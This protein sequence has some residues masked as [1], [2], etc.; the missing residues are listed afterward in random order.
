MNAVETFGDVHA[1]VHRVH[2]A[3]GAEL[4]ITRVAPIGVSPH[5]SPVVLV[6]GN[7][8]R[9]NFWVSP[10]GLGLAPFL[11]RRG[12]DAWVVE[13]RGH[14][15]SPKGERFSR[16]TAE[17]HV[18]HDLPCVQQHVWRAT[19]RPAMWIGHSAGGVYVLSALAAAWLDRSRVRGVAT[20]GSQLRDGERYLRSA[21][22]RGAIALALRTL[23]HLPAPRLGL[24]PEIEPA[25]EI[26][27]IMRWK[28]GPGRWRARDGRSY[29]DGL[30]SLD[31][32]LV[33][34]AGAGDTQDPPGGCRAL[35]DLAGGT[36]KT[37]VELGR[38]GGF[39]RD[40]GH[41]DMLVSKEAA[42]EVWPLVASWL[43]ARL[44]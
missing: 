8:A 10:K 19:N 11:A 38:A 29:A 43:E 9:R 33:S 42:N 24:G 40:F 31:L 22:A 17:D 13:L 44:T 30:A 1:E 26:I 2:A 15:L 5:A 41:V 20:F 32:P 34:F 27:E 25:E 16:I 3:D 23:G 21:A 36:D 18:R 4:A 6:H 14:G 12:F 37:F 35:L 7:Y 39:T 28:G